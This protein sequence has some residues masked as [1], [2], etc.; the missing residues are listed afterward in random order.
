MYLSLVSRPD[1]MKSITYLA[2]FISAFNNAHWVAAK[3]ILRYLKETQSLGLTF[4][5]GEFKI[6]GYAD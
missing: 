4:R 6:I 5:K 2:Q 1:I 3:R